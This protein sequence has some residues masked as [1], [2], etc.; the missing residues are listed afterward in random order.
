MHFS[1][2]GTKI[3]I[4][5][6]KAGSEAKFVNRSCSPNAAVESVIQ[7]GKIRIFLYSSTIIE[8]YKEVIFIYVQNL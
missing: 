5:A 2:S 8:K 3:F 4:D 1:V 6:T 7:N